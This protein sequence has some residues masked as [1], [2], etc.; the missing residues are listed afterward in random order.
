M[1]LALLGKGLQGVVKEGIDWEFVDFLRYNVGL[2]LLWV[3]TFG[4]DVKEFKEDTAQRLDFVDSARS[5]H[6]L[7]WF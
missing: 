7:G 4:L 3:K 5:I 6:N 1:L 2:F